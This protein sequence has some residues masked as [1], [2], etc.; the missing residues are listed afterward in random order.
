MFV[1]LGVVFELIVDGFFFWAFTL[2][3][4]CSLGCGAFQQFWAK[5]AFFWNGFVLG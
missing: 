2:L 5:K 1:A 3:Q 4:V